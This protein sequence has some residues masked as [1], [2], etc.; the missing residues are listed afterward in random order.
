MIFKKAFDTDTNAEATNKRLVKKK[1]VFK[2]LQGSLSAAKLIIPYFEIR[3]Y[4]A[5]SS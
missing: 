2:T 1:N 4:L 5:S 3:K